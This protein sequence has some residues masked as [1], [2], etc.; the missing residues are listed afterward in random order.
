M[1]SLA[2]D[3]YCDEIAYQVGL[4][5]S[6][7]SSGADLSGAVPTCPDCPAASPLTRDASP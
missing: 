1:T 3:R 5:R 7:V 4:L 6:V 2:H